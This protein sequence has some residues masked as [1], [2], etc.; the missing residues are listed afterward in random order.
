MPTKKETNNEPTIFCETEYFPFEKK[1]GPV[2]FE[3]RTF[4]IP[5]VF[6]TCR[7]TVQE[8]KKLDLIKK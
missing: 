3:P 6:V 4:A 5:G 7:P 1:T 8:T 2:R